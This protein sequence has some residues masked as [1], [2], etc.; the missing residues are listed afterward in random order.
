MG[1]AQGNAQ[2]QALDNPHLA[3]RRNPQTRPGR[4]IRDTVTEGRAVAPDA[5]A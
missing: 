1:M 2:R 3:N 4:S 5:L